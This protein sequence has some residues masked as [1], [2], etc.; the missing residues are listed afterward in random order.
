MRD[1]VKMQRRRSLAEFRPRMIPAS[2]PECVNITMW[3]CSTTSP[4]QQNYGKRC[5]SFRLTYNVTSICVYYMTKQPSSLRQSEDHKQILGDMFVT[6][7][8]SCEI[9]SAV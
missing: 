9:P 2:S 4:C 7:P 6:F 5:V 8:G 3:G 1:D